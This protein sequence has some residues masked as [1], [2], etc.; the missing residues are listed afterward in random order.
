M[1]D[2][3]FGVSLEAGIVRVGHEFA[4]T[5]AQRLVRLYA[6]VLIPED[7]NLMFGLGV[8]DAGEGRLIQG[9]AQIHA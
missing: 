5:N 3:D 7:E 1:D 9:C 2:H 6:D 8:V 4:E